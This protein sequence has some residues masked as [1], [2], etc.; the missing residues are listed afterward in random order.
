MRI[1]AEILQE[2]ARRLENRLD[3][4]WTLS[5]LAE[6]AGYSPFYLH[7]E[8]ER[9]IGEAPMSYLRRLRLERAAIWLIYSDRPIPQIADAC[10]FGSRQGFARAF[11]RRFGRAPEHYRRIMARRIDE[12]ARST[13]VRKAAREVRVLTLTGREIICVRH[14]GRYWKLPSV[15]RSIIKW[16]E[17]LKEDERPSH[18]FLLNYDDGFVTKASQTRYDLGCDSAAPVHSPFHRVVLPEGPVAVMEFSGRL[19]DWLN[20]WRWF[21]YCLLRES[22]WH[23][24]GPFFWDQVDTVPAWIRHGPLRSLFGPAEFVSRLHIPLKKCA[25]CECIPIKSPDCC[26]REDR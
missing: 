7:H 4:P 1:S 5:R 2:I 14:V 6:E 12:R 18:Y 24:E 3:E 8:F 13:V 10:G 9:H 16:T 11:T 19:E 20:A 26:R 23:V 25:D 21:V 15:W 22:G 17:G